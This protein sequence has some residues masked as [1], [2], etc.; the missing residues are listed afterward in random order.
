MS[1]KEVALKFNYAFEGTLYAP[2]GNAE[3]GVKEGT[4]APYDM[5]FGALA[6]CLYSTFLDVAMKKRISYESVDLLVTGEKRKEI[7]ST[8]KWVH[9]KAL[10]HNPEK[11]LGL[12]QAFELATRFC[13]IYET[14]SKVAKMTYEIDFVYDGT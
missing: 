9:V 4:L 11:E 3:I 12:E 2:N 10:V 14:I 13:S 8:L 1:V 5:L 7:P 6:G